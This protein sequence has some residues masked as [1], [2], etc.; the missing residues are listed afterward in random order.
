MRARLRDLAL[1]VGAAGT[2][3]FVLSWVGLRSM[4]FTYYEME[5][6]PSLFALRAGDVGGFL[7]GLPS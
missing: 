2:I 3:A 1:P 5:A 4:A 6:E 7:D